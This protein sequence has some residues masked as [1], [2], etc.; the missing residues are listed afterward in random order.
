MSIPFNK[1][2][3]S[4][5]DLRLLYV[6]DNLSTQKIM[7]EMLENFFETIDVA[8]DGLEG[9]E[10]AMINRYDLIITDINMPVMSGLEMI[11]KIKKVHKNINCLIFSA[12]SDTEYLV[13]SIKYRIDGYLIKPIHKEQFFE[14]LYKIIEKIHLKQENEQYKKQL[15]EQNIQLDIFS[16]S[17]QN[18]VDEQVNLIRQK[19]Q[20]LLTK[21]K[22]EA[23]GEMIDAIA[24][25][26]SQPIT[27]IRMMIE[28]LELDIKN[29]MND[30]DSY[31]KSFQKDALR[32]IDHLTETLVEFRN[33]FRPNIHPVSFSIKTML[34]KVILLTKDEMIMNGIKINIIGDELNFIGNVN[35]FK[36]IFINFLNNSKN[37]FNEKGITNREIDIRISQNKQYSVIEYEDNAGGIP[38]HII[39][40]LFKTNI[41]TKKKG[42]GSGLGLFLCGQIATKNFVELKVENTIRGAKFSLY[43]L[44]NCEL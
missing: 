37:A 21:S 19:D 10:K 34:N 24:H 13:D 26:W 12:Y 9:Y 15:E 42:K 23:M 16:R 6:E 30:I 25:Q 43:Q 33:F 8:S 20:L 39:K 40:T 29:N 18:R 35:E 4:S 41:T 2:S 28:L 3:N 17:L 38:E 1:I 44:I 36:H 7:L 22:N 27:S 32:Q 14:T 31:V 5:K 11:E